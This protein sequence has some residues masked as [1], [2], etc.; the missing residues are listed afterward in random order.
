[1]KRN[2]QAIAVFTGAQQQAIVK[3]TDFRKRFTYMV[4]A[5]ASLGSFVGGLLHQLAQRIGLLG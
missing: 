2:G 1:M 5:S 4:I 3:N